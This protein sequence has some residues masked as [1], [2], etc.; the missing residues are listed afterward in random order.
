M[1]GDIRCGV[2]MQGNEKELEDRV[3][4]AISFFKEGYNCA[5][6][7]LKA[8][9]YAP[10]IA[11]AFGA[12]ISRKGS[13]C[14]AI[15]GGILVINLKYGRNSAKEDKEKV[16]N[17]ALEYIDEFEEEFGNIMCYDLIECDLRTPEC[18]K[19]YKDQNLSDEECKKFIGKTIEILMR[20]K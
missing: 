14:G 17:A 9:D 18:Q 15:A 5:E 20:H 6:S 12:G 3:N 2:V 13:V 10:N 7:I 8:M 19:K 11:T 4:K 16:Y 1:Y